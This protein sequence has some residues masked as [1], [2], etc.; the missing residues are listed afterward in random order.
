MAQNK[1][2]D[3]VAKSMTPSEISSI[4]AGQIGKFQ[5][6][7]GAALRKSDLPSA[8]VQEVLERQGDS[9]AAE[10]VG[11]IR[12]RVEAIFTLI[13]RR[14]KVNRAQSPEEALKATGRNIYSDGDVVVSMPKGESDKAEVFFFN[15]GRFVSDEELEKEYEK[16]GLK[17]ADPYSLSAVNEDDPAFADSHPNGTHWKNENGKW[18]YAAFRRWVG[19]REVRV[20]R[21][22]IVWYD[23][24]WFAGLRK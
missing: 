12:T 3:A 21:R 10:V 22:V 4:T 6:L 8:P 1:E 16:R 9:L 15:L 17:A 2:D 11:A 18:C 23:F 5:E 20:H 19:G 24:W 7:L 13:L 14:V